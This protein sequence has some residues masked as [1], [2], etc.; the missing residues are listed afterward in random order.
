MTAEDEQLDD[1][2]ADSEGYSNHDFEPDEDEE[3]AVNNESYDHGNST[4]KL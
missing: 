3:K 2:K 4:V 1:E